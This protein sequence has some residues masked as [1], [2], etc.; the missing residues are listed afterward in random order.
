MLCASSKQ[1][2]FWTGQLAALGRINALTVGPDQDVS[3]LVAVVPFGLPDEPPVQ[4]AHGIRGVI[5]GIGMDD[6]VI[7]WGGGV[8]NWFDPLTLVKAIDRL[9]KRH[10]DIRLYFMGLKHPNPGVPDMRVAWETQQLAKRLGL[11]GRHV[12][13]N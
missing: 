5:P 6:K 13:F 3:S 4:R 11:V 12:F 10:P 8:Y 1:R 7:I 9:S 2:D